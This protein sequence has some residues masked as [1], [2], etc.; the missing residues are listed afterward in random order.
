M[1]RLELNDWDV[2]PKL[3]ARVHELNAEMRRS[4]TSLQQQQQQAAEE[5]AEADLTDSNL[6]R[7]YK[8]KHASSRRVARTM[9]RAGPAPVVGF[10]PSS[11]A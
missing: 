10:L 5:P 9:V 3:Q 8:L 6:K 2:R 4:A 1:C 7:A 11:A